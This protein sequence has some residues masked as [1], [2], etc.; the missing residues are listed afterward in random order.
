MPTQT[1][2]PDEPTEGIQPSI[3][4][5]PSERAQS[6]IAQRGDMAILLVEQYY[7]FAEQLADHHLVMSAWRKPIMRGAAK[8]WPRRA[9]GVGTGGDVKRGNVHV[10]HRAM[11]TCECVCCASWGQR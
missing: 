8:R 5:Q 9:G 4:K 3:I 6:A 11:G 7:D 10:T 1:A 2:D